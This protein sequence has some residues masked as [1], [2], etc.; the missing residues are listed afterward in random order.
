MD[1]SHFS[2]PVALRERSPSYTATNVLDAHDS[3]EP[4]N[5]R[6][7]IGMNFLVDVEPFDIPTF[8]CLHQFCHIDPAWIVFH[9]HGGIELKDFFVKVKIEL[10]EC[11]FAVV[12]ELRR[13]APNDAIMGSDALLTISKDVGKFRFCK[14]DEQDNNRKS[15]V[16]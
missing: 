16:K 12:K 11:S 8:T 7:Y 4:I 6:M 13:P 15:A 2:R 9:F 5:I 10:F 1:L 14:P 3:I